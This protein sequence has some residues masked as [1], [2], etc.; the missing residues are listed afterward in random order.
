MISRK[1][2][3]QTAKL[4]QQKMG[5]SC[6]NLLANVA[7]QQHSSIL[8]GQGGRL[9]S[10]FNSSVNATQSVTSSAGKQ[11]PNNN[12]YLERTQMVKSLNRSFKS[13]TKVGSYHNPSS[14]NKPA[15]GGG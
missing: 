5:N 3:E 13:D 12:P 6:H 2:A 11:G 1:I 15:A 4:T 7:S 14:S 10:K 9:T 8:G